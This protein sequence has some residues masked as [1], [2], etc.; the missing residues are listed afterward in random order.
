MANRKYRL[1]YHEARMHAVVLAVVGWLLVVVV[2]SAGRGNRSLV[3]SLKWADFV[4][5]YTLGDAARTRS[6][7]VLYDQT[8]QHARQAALVPESED[9][10]FIPVYGPQTAL[11]FAPFSLLSY[12][13]A[14]LLWALLTLAVYVWAVWLSWRPARNVLPDRF[15]VFVASLASPPLWFLSVYGQSTAFVIAAFASAWWALEHS[16]RFAAG[17]MLSLLAIK[18][19]FGLVLAV[20]APFAYEG[21]ILAGIAVGMAVQALAVIAVFGGSAL[22][23]Y[24]QALRGLP[25]VARLLEPTAFRMH[26]LRALT[27]LAGERGDVTLWA[28]GSLVIVLVTVRVWRQ[29]APWRVR[30]GILVLASALV[31]P[32]LAIYDVAVIALPI[33]WIGGWLLEEGSDTTWYWQRVYFIAAALL[34]PTAAFLRIQLSAILMLELFVQIVRVAWTYQQSRSQRSLCSGLS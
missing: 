18:P 7:A 6:T 24:A 9:D 4:H 27:H 32:H 16:R 13:L 2:V 29:P 30:F 22:A 26:S 28:I 1:R 14:G 21:Q 33:I 17:L 31:N 23:M 34:I 20:V 15:F 19:Q 11:L 8:V 5:F 3:G 25:A 10:H 12:F